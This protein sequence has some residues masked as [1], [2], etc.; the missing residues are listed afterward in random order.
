MTTTTHQPVTTDS[1]HV[2]AV[3]RLACA[4]QQHPQLRTAEANARVVLAA[5]IMAM[6]EACDTGPAIAEQA[7]V[8]RAR[9]AYA[10]ALADLI[11]GESDSCI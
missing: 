1:Q 2:A 8:E 9:H 7:A 3:Y 4:R 11:R 10:V 6:D 5:A